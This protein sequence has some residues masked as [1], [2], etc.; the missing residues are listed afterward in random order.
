M[1][2]QY[3]AVKSVVIL[4]SDLKK[5][6]NVHQSQKHIFLS[7]FFLCFLNNGRRRH[8]PC[9]CWALVYWRARNKAEEGSCVSQRGGMAY[10]GLGLCTHT[11]THSWSWRTHGSE[12]L[13]FRS[14]LIKVT[15][16]CAEEPFHSC[17]RL[18]TSSSE[19]FTGMQSFLSR[20]NT[21]THTWLF[22]NG[23]QSVN[24]SI[25]TAGSGHGSTVNLLEDCILFM[26]CLFISVWH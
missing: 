1:N 5:Q 17:W 26:V 25:I 14:R 18:N 15:C 20:T 2:F 22:P 6:K 11:H 21:L 4:L 13:L 3:V 10:P 12:R 16:L 7:L 19:G 8:S 24:L 9:C 23:H